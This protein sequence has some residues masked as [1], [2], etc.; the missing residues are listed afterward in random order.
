MNDDPDETIAA[1]LRVLFE[2]VDP[3]PPLVTQAANAALTWRRVDAE[4][5]EL[6]GDS[7]D[8]TELLAGVR[9][10][11]APIRAVTMSGGGLTIDIQIVSDGPLRTLL[12]QLSPQTSA[13][14][15]IQTVDGDSATTESDRSGRFT[16][17]LARGTQIRLR[18][19]NKLRTSAPLIETSW[20]AVS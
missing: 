1:E 18:I 13:T 2:Y 12:G 8:Q 9:S 10:S 17:Q 19:R 3:V 7:A 14:I 16:A 15:E 11:D 6:L 5:A 20:I 4:L